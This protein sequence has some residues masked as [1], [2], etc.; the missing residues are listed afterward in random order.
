MHL[1]TECV[2]K[3][4]SHPDGSKWYDGC[5]E[6][7]CQNGVAACNQQKQQQ[8]CSG[9]NCS[10]NIS[11][12]MPLE[13]HTN[14]HDDNDNNPKPRKC[15]LFDDL[16]MTFKEYHNGQKWL[17]QCQECE[18]LVRIFFKNLYY[19]S[20]LDVCLS[21]QLSGI[22]LFISPSHFSVSL[23]YR[24]HISALLQLERI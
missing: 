19:Y 5:T 10:T 13:C 8:S 21:F 18:C 3:G 9:R 1:H 20:I 11:N 2:V 6:C 14:Y 7:R 23:Y 22:H 15:Q 17:E 12:T 16:R 4:V 24:S